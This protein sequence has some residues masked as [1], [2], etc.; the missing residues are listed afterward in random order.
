MPSLFKRPSDIRRVQQLAIM[1]LVTFYPASILC[2]SLKGLSEAG[3]SASKQLQGMLSPNPQLT[4]VVVE[5]LVANG[6]II[7]K[8]R[9][10][11]CYSKIF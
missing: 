5:T 2:W 4:T 6:I 8:A 9:S 7:P 1:S 3:E 10:K 11:S